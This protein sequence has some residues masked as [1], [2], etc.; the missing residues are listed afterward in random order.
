MRA[1]RYTAARTR[2]GEI[3]RE[4]ETH[5]ERAMKNVIEIYRERKR[6]I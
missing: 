6:E 5:R 1:G 4:R 2:A 3:T